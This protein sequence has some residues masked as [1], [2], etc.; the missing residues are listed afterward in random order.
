[1]TTDDAP[2]RDP[3]VQREID[4]A[5]RELARR[6]A[7]WAGGM[8][9]PEAFA[10]EFFND[11]LAAQTWRPIPKP[12]PLRAPGTGTGPPDEFFTLTEN[13]RRKPR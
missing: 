13:I 5:V 12:A 2:D 3:D 7:G 10:R 11:M 8:Q 6:L 1:M 4:V 9:N